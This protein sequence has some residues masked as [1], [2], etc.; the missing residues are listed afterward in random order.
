M[1]KT[2]L[3]SFFKLTAGLLCLG[4]C[5]CGCE[6]VA[7]G[8]GSS[9]KVSSDSASSEFLVD[10]SG[11]NSS[12]PTQ[13][14]NA[15]SSKTNSSTAS[16]STQ[17]SSV[18]SSS[19]QTSSVANSSKPTSSASSKPSSATSSKASSAATSSASYDGKVG[20]SLVWSEEFDGSSLDTK[21][22]WQFAQT[23]GASD[24][25]YTN[26]KN[27]VSVADGKLTLTAK[28]YSNMFFK[29]IKYSLPQGLTTMDRM[30]FTYGYLEMRAKV[31]FRRGAWPSFWMKSSGQ[32][33]RNGTNKYLAEVDIFE[34]FANGSTLDSTLHKWKWNSTGTTVTNHVQWQNTYGSFNRTYTFK[35]SSNLN[36][37]YHLYALEWTPQYMAFFVDGVQYAKLPITQSYDFGKSALPG[38]DGFHEPFYIIM[39]NEM[40]TNP[41]NYDSSWMKS[42]WICQDS[43]L[44]INYVIDYVRLYQKQGETINTKF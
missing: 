16:S 42:S 8:S 26:D 31:P 34:V 12:T 20:R 33:R 35:N 4:V 22:K 23:M 36:N 2:T 7:T 25:Y 3:R 11:Q 13:T 10:A 21:T 40:I 30:E 38:M 44:P 24:R 41:G 37:E 5:L 17:T 19:T 15:T 43:D 27:H 1:N 14:S 39:N 32:D 28:S 18:A 29:N 6:P 9:K